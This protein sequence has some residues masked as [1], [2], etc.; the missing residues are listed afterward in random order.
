MDSRIASRSLRLAVVT[1]A[2]ALGLAPLFP[3]PARAC[4]CAIPTDIVD[5]VD[6]S[7]A[8]FVGSLIEKRDAEGEHSSSIYVF[9]VEEWVKGD[10]GTVIEVRSASDGGG[11]G[12][13]FWGPDRRIGAIIYEEGGEF[14]G[15]LCSQVEPDV[16]LS[17]IAGPTP[18]ATGIAHLLA[19]NGWSSTRLAV[20]DE[21]GGHVIDLFPPVPEREFNGTQGLQICPDGN[22]MLQWTST[23]VVT[24]NLTTLQ[25]DVT[26]LLA[27]DDGSPSIRAVSCRNA[28]ASSIWVVGQTE[29][30]FELLEIV[31]GPTS[32][33][34]LEG[35]TF[36]IGND[37]VVAQSGP[38]GDPIRIDVDTGKEIRLHETP[39]GE[40]W[41]VSAAPHPGNGTLALVETRRSPGG[42]PAEA[43]LLLV[44]E[45]GNPLQEF[46][47]PWE[48]Y[49]PTWLDEERLM[50]KAYNFENW[51][52]SLGLIYDLDEGKIIEIEGWT[53]EYPVASGNT[54]YG[55]DGGAIV[56]ADLSTGE[57]A[58]LVTLPT[59]FAGPLVLLD[60]GVQIA[61][62]DTIPP[63]RTPPTTP[64]LLSPGS[65]G[66]ND[67][68]ATRLVA[69][70]AIVVF[71]GILVWLSVSRP[72]DSR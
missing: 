49:S 69:G 27:G 64:P 68:T 9:E 13:E 67:S 62:G 51:E 32:I 14:H 28:E 42:G 47:I 35:D 45:T 72:A 55:A 11:C 57:V 29:L 65:E 58:T 1:T 19:G 44:D 10:L 3:A 38:D 30:G 41:P 52:E 15:G 40:H 33:L 60:R 18:S 17:A 2:F 23:E 24:W 66:A 43:T 70:G 34:A 59:Q 71:L 39:S 8:A 5:W 16:L 46:E 25:P 53:G 4:S 63:P 54:L 20:L 26:Y 36:H 7:E 37:F 6:D 50:V 22:R 31:D 12:F 56:T 48:V 21:A 61:A